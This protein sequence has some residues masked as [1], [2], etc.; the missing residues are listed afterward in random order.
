MAKKIAA[1][2]PWDCALRYL[3]QRS[4]SQHEIETKLARRG[5][6]AEEIDATMGRL[7]RADLI[8]DDQF[9]YEYARSLFRTKKL[10]SR[11]VA[12]R[13]RDKG[14]PGITAE[15]VLA[16][17]AD[18]G[19]YERALSVAAKKAGQMQGLDPAVQERRLLAFLARRGFTQSTCY[20]V[21]Q[22]VL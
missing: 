22:A 6:A 11:E 9:A 18:T 12:R 7:L 1:G 15:R 2:S 21:T 13:L 10:S 5:F 16:E 4:H 17:A 20:A 14:V 8:D 3:G 19:D